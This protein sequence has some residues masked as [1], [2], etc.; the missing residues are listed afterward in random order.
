M[1]F[2]DSYQLKIAES[3]APIINDF[4]KEIDSDQKVFIQFEEDYCSWK[5][6]YYLLSVDSF[7]NSLIPFGFPF[8]YPYNLGYIKTGYGINIIFSNADFKI[9]PILKLISFGLRNQEHI[10]ENQ[11]YFKLDSENIHPGTE[12]MINKYYS[13]KLKSIGFEIIDSLIQSK[14]TEIETKY[15]LEKFR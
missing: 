2:E 14:K 9:L 10:T 4:I 15:L 13:K 5:D 7:M 8:S 12:T 3:Y 1:G 6:E 11:N